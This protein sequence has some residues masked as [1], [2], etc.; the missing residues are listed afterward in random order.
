MKLIVIT[1]PTECDN[2]FNILHEIAETDVHAIHL[3]KPEWSEEDQ[4]DFLEASGDF[5]REKLV[6]HQFPKHAEEF[7]LK[8]WHRNR[9]NE[10]EEFKIGKPA[11]AAWHM[12]DAEPFKDCEYALCS[13]IFESISKPG[14]GPANQYAKN[15][16]MAK[17][18]TWENETRKEDGSSVPVKI[19][20]SGI[21]PELVPEAYMM[22]F[23][24]VAVLG[25]VWEHPSHPMDAVEEM[26][27]ACNPEAQ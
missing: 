1:A 11:S 16:V 7:N 25:Y 4:K 23:D 10:M 5:L 24:G 15:M 20:L 27:Y 8:G 14:H 21:T 22:G 6:I 13:P 9:A 2:E 3:R 26:L 12:Q 19:A 17:C 18:L